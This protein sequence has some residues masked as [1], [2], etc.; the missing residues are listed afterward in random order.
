MTDAAIWNTRRLKVRGWRVSSLSSQAQGLFLHVMAFAH[1]K[2]VHVPLRQHECFSRHFARTDPQYL[3]ESAI[4][5]TMARMLPG[6]IM[7]SP[8]LYGRLFFVIVGQC[9]THVAPPP[10]VYHCTCTPG[11][12]VPNES[13]CFVPGMPVVTRDYFP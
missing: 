13:G 10:L 1:R 2:V 4:S 7:I 6:T 11:N 3:Q 9:V 8:N 12:N 5:M